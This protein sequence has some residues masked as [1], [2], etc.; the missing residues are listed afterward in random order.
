MAKLEVLVS[1]DKIT[2]VD[3]K[4]KAESLEL[5]AVMDDGEAI[6]AIGS[7]MKAA[8]SASKAAVSLLS[9]ILD[10]PRLDGYRGVTPANEAVPSEL[11]AAIREIETE[12]LKPI[13][14][15]PHAD[16]GAKPATVEKLW[17]DYASGLKAGGSYAVAK[18]FVTMLFAYTGKL[19]VADNGKLFTVAAIK[20][21]VA[22]AK[23]DTPDNGPKTFSDKLIAM[24]HEMDN[25]SESFEMGS[26]ASAIAALKK[27]LRIAEG[28]AQADAAAAQVTHEHKQVGDI[29]AQAKAI[30]DKA[31]AKA[32]KVGVALI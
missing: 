28:F 15:K 32:Q 24:V 1:A 17:Q 6:R 20:K 19:P 2:F 25:R 16:K 18:S 9:H 22:N 26:S 5:F 8:I 4:G 23:A 30:S 10:N 31:Y 14:C 21:L 12:Y 13:F 27:M 3:S 11:K 7:E 29:A